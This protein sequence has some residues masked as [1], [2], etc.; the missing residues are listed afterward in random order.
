MVQNRTGYIQR[1]PVNSTAREHNRRVN[2]RTRC[3]YFL[4][5]VINIAHWNLL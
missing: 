5:S 4:Y 1:R 3:K 2:E